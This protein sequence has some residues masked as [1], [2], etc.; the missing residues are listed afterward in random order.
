MNFLKHFRLMDQAT[1]AGAGGAGGGTSAAATTAAAA[2]TTTTTTQ[3]AGHG[4][5]WLPA[6]ADAELIG[7][8][9]NKAWTNPVDAIKGHRELEKL[10]GADRAGRTVTIPTDPTAP[11]WAQVYD[12]LGR[13]ASPDAYKLS[14]QK[15]ADPVF[16]KQ[17]GETF[18]KLGLSTDQVKGLMDWYN[19]FGQTSAQAQ[20]AQA[21]AALEAEHAALEKDWGTGPDAQARRELARRATVALGLDEAAVDAMEKVAGFSKVMKAMAKVGDMLREAGAEGLTDV[22]SFGT[23]PEGAKAKKSQLMADREYAKRAMVPNSKEWAEFQRLDRIIA[24]V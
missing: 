21:Q 16:T 2:T 11:E 8:V 18:H 3:Q 15:G 10:L 9:Q 13:P 1:D 22:G 24:G 14:E 5:A 17:A 4:I 20:E 6:D 7:H 19:G 12:K 23:T